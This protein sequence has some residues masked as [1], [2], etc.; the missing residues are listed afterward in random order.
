MKFGFD[1][2]DTLINLRGYAF[3]I[4]NKK[5]NKN[6]AMDI[7]EALKTVEIHEPFGLTNAEGKEM[8]NTLREEIY[9]SDCP[10]Y[11]D[12][13]ETLQELKEQGHEIYYI[14]ARPGEHG[15]RTMNWMKKQGFPVDGDKFYCGMKD[16]EKVKIIE[17]LGLDFY[18]DDK[19]GVLDTLSSGS[20]RVVVRD[21]SYN[22]HLQGERLSHWKE[23][24][25]FLSSK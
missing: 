7:F 24:K 5:L 18:F 19:P 21:Q 1:I 15:E 13:V 2:D 23:I 3:T 22:R 4:Y 17:E 10:P 25:T 20:L 6:L 11:P 16:H 9:F 14:T 8:W 12:A